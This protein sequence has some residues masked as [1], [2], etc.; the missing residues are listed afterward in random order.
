MEIRHTTTP[1]LEAL[2]DEV[3]TW[4]EEELPAEYEG[5]HWDFEEDP[6]R[7]AFYRE[8]WKKQGA[9][10]L[11]RAGLAERVRRR[12]D[13]AP[14]RQRGPGRSSAGAG[15]AAWRESA[16]RSDR[17]S[18]GSAPTEQKAAFLPGMAAGEIMWGE[19]YTEPNAGSDLASLTTRAERDGDEWVISGEKT[20]CT[21]GHHCN[22][23]IIAA[24]TDPDYSMR[25]R[26]ISYFVAPMDAPGI[27]LRPLYNIADGRQNRV[28]LDELRVPANRLLGDLNQGWNQIWFG[29]GGNPIPEFADDD[30]GPEMDY[31]PPL[32]GSAVGARPAGA[33]LPGDR[34][35][36]VP[37]SEDPVVRM[38]LTDLAMEVEIQ[39]M[40]GHEGACAV[41]LPPAPGHH[42][43][44][45]APLRPDVHGD[46]RAAR[47]DPVRS[48]GAAG[49]GD[50]PDLPEVLRQP[51]RRDLPAQADGRGDARPRTAPLGRPAKGT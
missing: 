25:H 44:V 47:P 43:G 45:P 8:F 31:E 3:R 46:P 40:L 20:F 36:G 24:R 17:P 16:C 18:S 49:R 48:V 14:R 41:R 6:D 12:R 38:Q 27:E 22:W 7:W 15:P 32:V 34:R 11:D 35:D 4:L 42:Q 1:K 13:V 28:Y 19:G 51:R 2:R 9:K 21:A 10:A 33:V 5:F 30:P 50:R 39:T 26:G 37:L 23:I 29:M